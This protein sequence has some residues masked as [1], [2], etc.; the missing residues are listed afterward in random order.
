MMSLPTE[1]FPGAPESVRA[2]MLSIGPRWAE[3][4]TTNSQRVKDAYAPLLAQ[5]PKTDISVMRDLAYGSHERQ[6]LD[7]FWPPRPHAAPVMVFVHG[8]AFVRGAKRVSDEL[9]DNV[10][11]WFARQGFVCV[12]VEYRLA[13]EATYPQGALDVAAA[14]EWVHA[15]IGG[16]GGDNT[17]ILLVGHSAG[18]THAAAYVFDPAVK[19]PACRAAALVLISAR[20]RADQLPENPNRLGVQTYFGDDVAAYDA[21]SPVTYA[22]GSALPT[23]VVVAEYENPLLDLYGLEFAWRL[24]QTRSH[25]PRFLQM[26]NHNHMSIMAHFNSGEDILG[27]QIVTFF[28]AATAS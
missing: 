27:R 10:L 13:P 22:H 28:E 5:A 18:G 9:Y 2:E 11:Y 4:I 3:D 6:V 25:A 12:N 21:K 7:I 17:R 23:M 1:P 20:L 24:A 14:M 26:P 16:Y 8:G 15:E 19:Q